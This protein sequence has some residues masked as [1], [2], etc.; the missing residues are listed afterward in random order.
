MTDILP[1]A[2]GLTCFIVSAS[3]FFLVYRSRKDVYAKGFIRFTSLYALVFVVVVGGG[4]YFLSV[5]LSIADHWPIILLVV[6]MPVNVAIVKGIERKY[7]R[8]VH[9]E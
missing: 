3:C 5:K 4:G 6:L 1:L 7:R 9:E 8:Q 2:F